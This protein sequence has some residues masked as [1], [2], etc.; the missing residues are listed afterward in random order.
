MNP[1]QPKSVQITPAQTGSVQIKAEQPVYGGDMLA[2]LPDPKGKPSSGSG[3]AVFVPLTLPGETVTVHIAEEK[4]TFAKAELQ[5]ILAASPERVTPG[6]AHFGICGGC[7][8]QHAGY[9]LQVAMKQQILRELLSRAGVA[10]PENIATLHGEKHQ[11][12]GYRNR[13]RLAVTATGELAYRGRGSHQ[14]IPIRECP[15]AAPILLEV[16][17]A[18]RHSLKELAISELELFTNPE[19]SQVLVTLFCDTHPS[20]DISALL[21]A[22]IGA[23]PQIS[24]IRLQLADGSLVPTILGASG[25]SQLRYEAAGFAYRVDHGAFFQVNRWLID[26]FV[27]LATIG[28]H[29]QAIQGQTAWDLYAGVG[30]FARKLTHSFAEVV[31]VESAPA[32]AAAMV[33]NL[34]GT[35]AQPVASTT[36][37]YLRRN[38]EDRSPRPDLILLDPPRAGLGDQVTTLLNAIGSPQIVYVSCDPTTLARDLRALTQERYRID[39]ITLVDLF[40]QT[41]H[42]ESVVRLS[43]S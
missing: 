9:E 12:W 29:G 30:L 35:V 39:Q 8:Y 43:R 2:H 3:K 25:Q 20:V 18:L 11:R 15:I 24:G 5:A 16:A 42:I 14:L 4:R 22:L 40:P 33:E 17:F 27:E 26:R 13:I 38:R 6:C 1:A 19:Q 21:Q 10:A 7:H 32:S 36:L 37:D 28:C 31:A 23:A 41:F 34:A